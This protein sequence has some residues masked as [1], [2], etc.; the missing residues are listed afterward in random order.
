MRRAKYGSRRI[1]ID[2]H[3]FMSEKEGRRYRALMLLKA[4]GEID[5]LV[6]QPR[7]PLV[8]EGQKICTYVADFSYLTRDGKLVTEDVKG[9]LTDLYKLKK[10]LV[11]A[12][13]NID[14]L[15]T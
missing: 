13:Y 15:E 4:A 2:G 1:T 14:I 8:V 6:L 3:N 10:K 9:V 7:F 5:T 12:L 11:K